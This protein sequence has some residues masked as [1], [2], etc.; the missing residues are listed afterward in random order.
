VKNRG[1]FISFEGIDGCGKTTQ[2]DILAKKLR[3]EK[4]RVLLTREPGGTPLAENIR[5]LILHTFNEKV[6]K[7]TE[8]LLYAA[9]RAQ[10]VETLIKPNLK[11]GAIVLTDR[12]AD[13]TVAYQGGG[14]N[15]KAVAIERLNKFATGGLEPDVTFLFDLPVKVAALRMA[16][17]KR[18]KDR[19]ELEGLAFQ[20]KVRRSF[21]K[22]AAAHKKRICI[23]D[24]SR[25]V[26]DQADIVYAAICR[27]SRITAE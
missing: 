12:F 20:E 10:H 19:L 25:S 21:L 5:N 6:A 8:L 23:I 9:A 22:I 2:I 26:E 15:I 17:G 7:E 18:K 1:L 4:K 14:R 16:K 3:K 27:V 13:S 11:S 24:A